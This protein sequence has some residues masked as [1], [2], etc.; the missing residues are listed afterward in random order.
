M[1]IE[2]NQTPYD[3]RWRMFGIDVRVHPMFWLVSLI[4]GMN[5]GGLQAIMIWIACVFVSI[6]VHEMGHVV[7]GQWFGSFGHIVLYGFGGLAVGS[8][9]L[10]QRWQRIAVSF[11]G[12]AAGFLFLGVL[13]LLLWI[14]NP[15]VFP[16]YVVI[17]MRRLGL[18]DEWIPYTL[19][20]PF[21][22]PMIA[23]VVSFLTLINLIW[24][25]VN[26]LPVWPLDG[27]QISREVCQAVSPRSGLNQSLGI[28]MAVAGVLAVHCFM[29]AA[30]RELLPLP[31][32]SLYS[33]L[34]FGILALHSYQMM[35]QSRIQEREWDD[36]WDDWPHRR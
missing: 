11:A 34:L 21:G 18:P 24:G 1:L 15:A 9:R 16:N 17:A 13:Y 29:T 25:L 27:G 28:S 19:G 7:V 26:L 30:G 10:H 14:T 35:Q 22:N 12:P 4:M 3:L 33:G 2:P 23:L 32:G 8:N 36:H 6:L 20:P 31:F 5:A